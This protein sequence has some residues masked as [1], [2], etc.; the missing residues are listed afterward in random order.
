[1]IKQSTWDIY[2][3]INTTLTFLR[4]CLFPVSFSSSTYHRNTWNFFVYCML[5]FPPHPPPS[6]GLRMS[7]LSVLLCVSNIFSTALSR[8]I[9]MY[10]SSFNFHTHTHMYMH[11]CIHTYIYIYIHPHTHTLAIEPTGLPK[12]D[13]LLCCWWWGMSILFFI[14][15]MFQV[16]IIPTH[17]T[18]S[19][20]RA[21]LLYAVYSTPRLNIYS[22]LLA[23]FFETCSLRIGFYVRF[24][25]CWGSAGPRSG[26]ENVY[27]YPCN[28]T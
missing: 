9:Y 7:P 2:T 13:Q 1:M 28:L 20:S 6:M 16:L 3:N 5:T 4:L 8:Y 17:T 18:P 26:C 27:L 15:Q 19:S 22:H 12:W 14:R 23:S 21:M 10:L 24:S 25:C 11:A